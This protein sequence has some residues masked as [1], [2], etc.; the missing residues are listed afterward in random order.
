MEDEFGVTWTDF[1]ERQ[2]D[3]IFDYYLL[4]VG[5]GVANKIISNVIRSVEILRSHPESGQ[6]EPSLP[7]MPNGV[8]YLVEGNY[9]I[10]YFFSGKSVAVIDVFDT[11]RNPKL[12]KRGLD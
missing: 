12:I 2:L 7:S 4:K 8:R 9:K 5:Y 6:M 1:A 10:L 3:L 11:R